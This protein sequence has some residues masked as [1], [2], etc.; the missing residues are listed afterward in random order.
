MPE[1]RVAMAAMLSIT[2]NNSQLEVR[3][4]DP[5]NDVHCIDVPAGVLGGLITALR[6]HA[7]AL[8]GGAGQPMTLDSGRPFTLADGRVGLELL[9]DGAVRLPVLFPKEAIQVLRKTL[10]ELERLST[11]SPHRPR[12]N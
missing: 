10:D 2:Q 11:R 6:S 7:A 8:P 5:Q 9:L 4:R 1:T 3:F 12:M